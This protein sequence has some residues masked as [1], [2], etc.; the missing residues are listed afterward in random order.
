MS[1]R[2]LAFCA[3]ALAV[4]WSLLCFFVFDD[5]ETA[6]FSPGLTTLGLLIAQDDE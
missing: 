3:V 2:S 4:A 6:L 1:D 5:A